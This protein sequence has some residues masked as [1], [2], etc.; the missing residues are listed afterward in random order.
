M[1]CASIGKPETGM[2]EKPSD[3]WV[4]ALCRY[5]HQDGILAQHKI[6][7]QAFWFEI[8]GRNPFTIAAELWQASGGAARA[9][10][11]KPAPRPR[12]IKPRKPKE[13]RAKIPAGRPLRSRGFEKR[14]QEARP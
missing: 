3:A 8:H 1:A 10:E 13:L 11:P 12:K 7:E 9:L 14:R 6:G 2:Q 5:H 4:T